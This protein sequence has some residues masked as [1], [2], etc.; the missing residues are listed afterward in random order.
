MAWWIFQNVVITTALAA[1]VL[2]VC[3][4]SRL[5][6]VARH[7]LWVLVLV[8]FVTP[9]IVAWPWAMP[10]PLGLASLD[11]GSP[12]DLRRAV[13]PAGID[14]EQSFVRD[15]A[16]EQSA[17]SRESALSGAATAENA[18]AG[19][20]IDAEVMAWLL[21]IWAAGSLCFLVVESVRW[22]RLRRSLADAASGDAAIV[23]RVEML[24]TQMGLSPVRVLT[25][26]GLESPFV[27]GGKQPLLL[28]P[29]ELAAEPPA[30]F[31]D[32]CI[33]GLLVHELAHI[34]R[35]DHLVGWVELAASIVWWWNPLF[36]FVRAARRE[37]AELACD[38][39]VI[40]ALPNG[41]RAY[42]ESLLALSTLS[43]RNTPAMAVGIRSRSRRALERR[44]VMIMKGRAALKLPASGL[45]T[46]ALLAAAT[47][48]TWA[49]GAQTQAPSTWT[50]AVT[51]PP[52]PAS[53]SQPTSLSKTDSRLVVREITVANDPQAQ[54]APPPPPPPPPRKPVEFEKSI[55]KGERVY[56]LTKLKPLPTE[57]EQLLQAFERDVEEIRREVER[58]SEARR[59]ALVKELEALQDKYSKAGQLDEA[60]AIRDYLRSGQPGKHVVVSKGSLIKKP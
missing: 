48:P 55:S 58:K 45:V 14:L 33:D 5:G 18:G 39:W 53:S 19:S 36:W 11:V 46:L 15:G 37:Q 22:L 7:A 30:P 12:T 1:T 27:Y 41:R 44:L 60:V 40:A 16:A 43:P 57:G 56:R 52:P 13:P 10:D 42:A 26:P 47:L 38:A 2:A 3:R 54:A 25:L 31:T 51:A 29:A 34:K 32:S 4:M 20:S 35:R 21:A 8:K 6:P 50:I 59:E 28:W 49:T 17:H 23:A 9:P 24:S